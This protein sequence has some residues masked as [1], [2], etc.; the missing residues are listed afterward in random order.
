MPIRDMLCALAAVLALG[1]SFVAIKIGVAH[2]PPLLLTALRF[3]FAAVPAVF[4]ISPPATPRRIVVVFGVMLGVV[5][6]GFLMTAIKLGMPAGLSSILMQL[7]AFFTVG[8]AW[9]FLSER[10]TLRQLAG[11]ALAGAGM[12]LIG[13]S[14]IGAEGPDFAVFL[15]VLAAAMGWSVANL[16]S[17]VAGGADRF[18]LVIWGC[19]VAPLPLLGLS[20]LIEGPEAITAAL[21]PPAWQAVL[22]VAFM[23]YPAT[24]MAMSVWSWLLS[25][26]S[27]AALAPFALLIPV[28]GMVASAL[29]FGE[30]L[31]PNEI[32]A[33]VLILAG[34][35][36]GMRGGARFRWDRGR[37]G[38]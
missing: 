11:A 17:K 29:T 8:L 5:Q 24:V 1:I 34:L 38:P 9:I 22:S 6:F 13:S 10:P 21:S 23:A 28:V 20:L 27:A 37:A 15:M 4:F 32:V 18:A 26:H 3:F 36:V 7:Q 16:M 12:M 31:G 14:W 2:M 25:R 33:S 30:E 19:L 35:A